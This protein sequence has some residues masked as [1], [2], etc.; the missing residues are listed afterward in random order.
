MADDLIK[1][2][3]KSTV[4]KSIISYVE[5]KLDSDYN[6]QILDL[7]IPKE[8]RIRSIVGGLETSMGRTLWEP[9][10]KALAINNGFTIVE[11]NLDAPANMPSI[12]SNT[13]SIIIEER[14][15]GSKTYNAESSHENIKK[16]CQSFVERP[17]EKFEKAPRGKGVD[18]WLNKNGID[19]FFDTKTVQPNVRSL[20]SYMEQVLI[21]YSYYYSKNPGGEAVA[22]I[23]FPYNP[24]TSDFWNNT[25][26]RGFPLEKDLEG[27]V[28]NQFWDF[29][30][31]INGTYA[32]ITESFSELSED[33]IVAS[34]IESM[35]S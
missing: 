7:L 31:G 20:T 10:A 19:Y 4:K 12:L 27:W 16:V 9:L 5:K 28:E 8:R 1:N 30:S 29:C 11:S 2:I 34:K 33:A 24:Y 18:I 15:K 26:G 14:K 23:V 25:K 6:S 13:L 3:I 21:W 22:R 17:I 32:L 35:F